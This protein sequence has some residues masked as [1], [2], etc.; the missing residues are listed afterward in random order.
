MAAVST[1]VRCDEW[2]Q[3]GHGREAMDGCRSARSYGV[4][5]S[6]NGAMA[7][8][9]WMALPL[10]NL[11]HPVHRFNGAM[12]VRPWMGSRREGAEGAAER[13]QWGHGREAMDGRA[14]DRPRPPAPM[15]SMGPWP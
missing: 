3:W 10:S 1:V 8:R 15:A 7:V 12:A 9:P 5:P 13:L 11:G 4:S 6:F 2:L 14:H